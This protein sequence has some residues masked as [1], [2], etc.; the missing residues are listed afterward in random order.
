MTASAQRVINLAYPVLGF[1]AL[2]AC[3]AALHAADIVSPTL[4]PSPAEAGRRLAV[5]LVQGDVLVDLAATL[6][7]TA[8]GLGLAILIGT[9]CGL[10][11][12]ML[13]GVDRAFGPVVDFF[14]SLPVT[15]LYPL[16]IL[17]FGI[18]TANR[19]AMAFVASVFVVILN[20]A[21]GVKLA[22]KTRDEMARLY[23]ATRFQR[24]IHITFF[25][26]LPH[27]IVGWRVALSYALIVSIVVEMFMGTQRGI[28]Q[29]V[30]D[31]YNTYAIGDLYG[32]VVLVGIVG[33]VLNL[34]FVFAERRAVHWVGR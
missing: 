18:G 31:A 13:P 3:W 10:A 5:L 7:R 6:G 14:R 28:G 33:Y 24:F 23:G 11:M 32:L 22:G 12:G 16:F 25:D 2:L 30:F 9:P 1:G 15:T 17:F 21:Y 26:A 34:A 4:L 8:A 29:R 20:T 19:I 27:T